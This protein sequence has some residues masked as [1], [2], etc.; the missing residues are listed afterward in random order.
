MST[1]LSKRG[2]KVIKKKFSPTKLNKVRKDLSVKPFTGF[3]VGPYDNTKPF[4][5]FYESHKKLYIPKHYGLKEFGVP[6]IVD[7][8]EGIDVDISFNGSMRSE[9]EMVVKKYMESLPEKGGGLISLPCGAGKTVI[10]LY[11]IS[12][13]KKKTIILVHKDF[14]MNQWYDRIKQFLPSARIGKIQQNTI[15]VADK[16]IVL[17]MVQSI[18]MKDYEMSIFDEFGLAVFDECHHLGAEVFSKSLL[19]VNS[20]YMLGLSA[21]PKRKDGLSKVF[22]WF[23]G[24]MVYC[25]KER[26]EDNVLVEIYKYYHESPDYSEELYTVTQNVCMPRMINNICAFGLRDNMIYDILIKNVAEGRDILI[27]SDRRQHLTN[28]FEHVEEHNIGSVGYYVGGMKPAALRDTTTKQII[29]GTFSMASE[30]MDIPK[31]NTIIL[32]SPK[33]DIVQSV[34]RILRQK[35][36]DRKHIPKI[37]DIMDDFSTFS[38]QATKRQ[39]YYKKCKYGI[40]IIDM[41]GEIETIDYK[42]KKSKKTKPKHIDYSKIDECIL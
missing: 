4:N 5:V 28:I 24:D 37:I 25:K 14:L 11:I 21:T 26:D 39:A 27:L 18:S 6:D 36:E 30:G 41:D 32:A 20:K 40:Q 38:K 42:K 2:Y 34:G 13:I 22:E 10:S 9:Q 12:L 35:A 33:S 16:D 23:I 7:E 31:L 1:I 3:S 15:D 29:L 19:K 17:A 8:V